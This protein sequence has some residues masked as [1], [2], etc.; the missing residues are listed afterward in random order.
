MQNA[1]YSKP[2]ADLKAIT[3]IIELASSATY[4]INNLSSDASKLLLI[5]HDKTQNTIHYLL[6]AKVIYETSNN[7]CLPNELSH[8]QLVNNLISKLKGD[9]ILKR[10]AQSLIIVAD[11]KERIDS[12]KLF[13][14]FRAV[15]PLAHSLG[16]VDLNESDNTYSATNFG[17]S[18]F[19]DY[20]IEN[21]LIAYDIG[22]T[23]AQLDEKM[24]LQKE[25][26]DLAESFILDYEKKRLAGHENID[27][28]KRVSLTNVEAGFDI[29]SFQS[30]SSKS[31]DKFIEV[32]SY[33]GQPGFYWSINE[34]KTA[35]EKS[36]MYYL[37]IVNYIMINDENYEPHEI[38]NPF[39]V[40]NMGQYIEKKTSGPF[41]ISPTN[42]YITNKY[43]N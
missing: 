1:D 29:Q 21:S 18:L 42:F 32:K 33:V 14:K 37:V 23:P 27:S 31:I 30:L 20:A 2:F 38:I 34:I 8:K 16:L 12:V 41:N 7:L 6:E 17:H 25:R 36:A 11:G 10:I 28:I 39:V 4:N 22:L 40:F 19:K 9:G 43:T 5:S 26:G 15:L 13:P 35:R 3:K 24:A